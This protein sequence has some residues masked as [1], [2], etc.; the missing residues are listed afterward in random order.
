[1][2]IIIINCQPSTFTAFQPQIT[3]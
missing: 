1:M 3:M 2:A